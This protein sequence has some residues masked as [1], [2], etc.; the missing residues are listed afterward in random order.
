[1]AGASQSVSLE[2][3]M[4]ERMIEVKVRFWTNNLASGKGHIRPRH[5]WASGVVRIERNRSHGIAPGHPRPFHSL[6][7][8]GAVI[9][10]VLMEHDIH[11]HAGRRMT[12]YFAV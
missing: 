5:A 12:K 1:M 9:E 10:K 8:V 4:G 2:A 3:E 11:L 6:L 7:D